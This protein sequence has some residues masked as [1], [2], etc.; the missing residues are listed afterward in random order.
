M[1]IR[2]NGELTEIDGALTL[3]Q[4][5]AQMPDLPENFAVA[6]NE[7]FVPRGAYGGTMVT[8]GDE[9]ELVVPMQG[10]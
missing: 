1:N 4:L 5:L 2:F 6:L 10:G 7:N 9:V 8:A 3:E